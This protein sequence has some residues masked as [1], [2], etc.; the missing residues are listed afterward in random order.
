MKKLALSLI[1][2]CS[3]LNVSASEISLRSG[4]TL[5]IK[6]AGC[7]EYQEPGIQILGDSTTLSA[8]CRSTQCQVESKK[9]TYEVYRFKNDD[10]LWNGCNE[11]AVLVGSFKSSKPAFTLSPLKYL[12]ADMQKFISESNQCG[13]LRVFI[14]GIYDGGKGFLHVKR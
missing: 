12:K 8:V 5:N 14:S 11:N 3:A 10:C 1:L 4:D 2:T 6:V 13:T 9:G 7:E